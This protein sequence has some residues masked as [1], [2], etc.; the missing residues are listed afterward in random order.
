MSTLMI[1]GA[2][3][4]VY[5]QMRQGMAAKAAADY[6]ATMMGRLIGEENVRASL[7]ADRTRRQ[8]RR[9]EAAQVAGY[10]KAGVRLE[11]TP[12][13]VLADTAT[14]YEED[15]AISDYN[16][17]IAISRIR[18]GI[19]AERIRG[20]EAMTTAQLQSGATIL[21]VASYGRQPSAQPSTYGYWGPGKQSYYGS[22]Y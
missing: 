6:N 16:R 2:A 7:I 19:S 22:P 1:V 15:I 12:L 18:A 14:Q 4:M 8:K 10:M 21:S 13:E 11:G 20:E 3:I 9:M 17:R 5:G